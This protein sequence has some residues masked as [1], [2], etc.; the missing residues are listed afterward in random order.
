MMVMHTT[1]KSVNEDKV[2]GV[3]LCIMVVLVYRRIIESVFLDSGNTSN[4]IREMFAKRCGLIG[5]SETLNVTTLGG[6]VIKLST[7][8][9]VVLYTPGRGWRIVR[10]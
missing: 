10:L 9:K 6:K 4:F 3:I 1:L 8:H 2:E 5:K 7:I